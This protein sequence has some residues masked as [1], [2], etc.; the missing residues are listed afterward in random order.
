MSSSRVSP[1]SSGTLSPTDVY[2]HRSYRTAASPSTISNR[3]AQYPIR[4]AFI[5]S[6]D[7]D[8]YFA[9]EYQLIFQAAV[10]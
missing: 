2:R 5:E 8:R 9:N 7:L 1:L 10:A 6:N 4:I 3:F